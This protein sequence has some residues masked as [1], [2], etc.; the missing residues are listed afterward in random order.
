[1]EKQPTLNELRHFFNTAPLPPPPFQLYQGPKLTIDP[2]EF[3]CLE[4]A[5]I[6]S[7]AS[8]VAMKPAIDRLIDLYRTLTNPKE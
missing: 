7:G 8:K 6:E 4:F 1:M 5:V 3:A 2:K